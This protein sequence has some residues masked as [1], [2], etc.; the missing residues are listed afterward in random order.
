MENSKTNK[1]SVLLT[2]M[3]AKFT[4]QIEHKEI[5]WFEVAGKRYNAERVIDDDGKIYLMGTAE[6]GEHRTALL[7]DPDTDI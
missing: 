2:K 4:K 3:I 5:Q 6:D 7:F 1:L